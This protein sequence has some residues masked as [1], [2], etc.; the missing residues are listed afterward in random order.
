M[1]GPAGAAFAACGLML[2]QDA[3]MD[4][5]NF[6]TGEIQGFGLFNYQGVPKSSYY[7][8][9]AF[10][11]LLDTPMRVEARG[12]I[13]GR[14][15]VLA[16]TDADRKHVGLPSAPWPRW[17]G[18]EMPRRTNGARSRC[19]S[20]FCNLPW[21]G[22]SVYEVLLIDDRHEL[23]RLGEGVLEGTESSLM[24]ELTAPSVVLVKLRPD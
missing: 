11:E 13:D 12:E 24:L 9:K 3:P 20:G 6:Y 14:M 22:R 1:S 8:F 19:P 10:R 23:T 16:G 7:A 4:V 15:A 5:A 21:S 18:M 2:L 17:P